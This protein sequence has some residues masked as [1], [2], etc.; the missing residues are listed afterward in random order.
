MTSFKQKGC[1]SCIEKP[2]EC[3]SAYLDARMQKMNVKL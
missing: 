1:N 2:T 3:R